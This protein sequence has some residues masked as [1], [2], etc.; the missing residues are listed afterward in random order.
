[1]DYTNVRITANNLEYQTSEF[2][3]RMKRFGIYGN[4][5]ERRLCH[6]D[7]FTGSNFTAW[8]F[9][10]RIDRNRSCATSRA[11]R[12][13]RNPSI[14]LLLLKKK[15]KKTLWYGFYCLSLIDRIMSV[16]FI[17]FWNRGVSDVDFYRRPTAFMFIL[18]VGNARFARSWLLTSLW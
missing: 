13:G 17:I 6:W 16:C 18:L 8:D 4:F 7:T 5:L 10:T 14:K 9:S 15:T 12:G 3:L 2:R 11:H 1:M